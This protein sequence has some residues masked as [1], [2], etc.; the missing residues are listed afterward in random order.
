M[1]LLA[2]GT[3]RAQDQRLVDVLKWRGTLSGTGRMTGADLPSMPGVAI[4]LDYNASFTASVELERVRADPPQWEGRVVSSTVT[5]HYREDVTSGDCV[6]TITAD[7]AGPLDDDAT[8]AEARL[9]FN[10]TRGFTLS[11]DRGGRTTTVTKRTVCGANI[12]L[13]DTQQSKMLIAPTTGVLPYPT[14]GFSLTGTANTTHEVSTSGL[15]M[16]SRPAKWQVTATLAPDSMETLDLWIENTPAYQQWRPQTTASGAPG[17]ALAMTATLVSSTGREPLTG[18]LSWTWE[19]LGTSKEPGVAMNFPVGAADAAFDLELDSTGEA[20][21]ISPDKQRVF[22]AVRS[23]F[24][25]TVQVLP[26]DWGA[27]S[28][29]KVTAALT[30]GRQVVGKLRGSTQENVRLPRRS[31]SSF[32]ADVWKES[33]SASGGDGE[34]LDALPDGDGTPG[35]GLSLYEEYRGF[36]EEG[37]HIEGKPNKKDFFIRN[38]AMAAALGGIGRFSRLSRLAVHHKLT[39]TELTVG[40]VI[41]GNHAAG[42]HVTDQHAIIVEVVAGQTG[43]AQ[44]VGGPANPK[45]ITRVGLMADWNRLDAGYLA[46]TVAHELFHCVNVWHHGEGDYA[47]ELSLDGVGELVERGPAGFAR[48]RV[49][50]EQGVDVTQAV[51]DFLALPSPN[52]GPRVEAVNV[53]IEAGQHSGPEN[54]VMRYD[55]AEFAVG[56][57]DPAIRYR[58]GELVGAGI[59]SAS[60]G[61]GVNLP[62]RAPQPRYGDPAPNRGACRHQLLVTDAVTAPGR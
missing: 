43:F 33:T 4:T 22:K 32:I 39:D 27:W 40:R 48:V 8:R 45:A 14:S 58:T 19:L 10:G 26:K 28:E 24:T 23:G 62:G 51:K 31:P 15:F 59:C 52:G 30:D 6:I 60:V 34:D 17:P 16:G 20:L 2:A 7:A 9:E 12:D 5:A 18:V 1:M 41:N 54:C 57:A 11:L 53:G 55:V 29:L 35:D 46:S 44:A 56:K 42:P 61:D 3:A 36:Y 50:T 21:E 49:L 25:D 38:K 37:I 47:G 13:T